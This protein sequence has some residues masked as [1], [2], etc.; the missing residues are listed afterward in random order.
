MN[1]NKVKIK[2]LLIE[3]ANK[4][5]TKDKLFYAKIIKLMIRYKLTLKDLD[6]IVIKIK[7]EKDINFELQF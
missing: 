6:E 3:G 7:N 4:G 5:K 1:K 2:N